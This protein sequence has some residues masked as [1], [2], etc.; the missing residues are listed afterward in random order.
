MQELAHYIPLGFLGLIVASIVYVR[1]G[2]A[3]RPTFGEANKLYAQDKVCQ[4]K[5]R[6]IDNVLDEVRTQLKNIPKIEEKHKATAQVLSEMKDQLKE[7]PE[8]RE[9]L[10]RLETKMDYLIRNG[11]GRS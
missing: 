2:L 4:E 8:M 9:A 6:V 10:V 3:K 11:N 5:H 1:T 7:I